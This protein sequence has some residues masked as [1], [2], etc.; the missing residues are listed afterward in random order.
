MTLVFLRA[1]CSSTCLEDTIFPLI[2]GGS[3][4]VRSGGVI[5]PLV[6]VI[7]VVTLLIAPLITTHEPASR[8][9]RS[10][11]HTANFLAILAVKLLH[12]KTV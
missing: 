7:T 8:F 6:W 2:L 10:Q 5:S 12:G 3:W 1:V 9:R 11:L 4:V